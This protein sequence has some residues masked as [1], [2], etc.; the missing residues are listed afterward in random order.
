MDELNRTVERCIQRVASRNL[1]DSWREEFLKK[2]PWIQTMPKR[3]QDYF[4]YVEYPAYGSTS[5][6]ECADNFRMAAIA[7][8]TPYGLRALENFQQRHDKGCCGSREEIIEDEN[9]KLWIVGF[10]YGH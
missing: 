9:G 3:I 2:Y 8:H 10:N 5:Q 4:F 6:I 1:E 7:D